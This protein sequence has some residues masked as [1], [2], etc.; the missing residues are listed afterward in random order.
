MT[1]QSFQS[2]YLVTHAKI[3]TQRSRD[4]ALWDS[5]T[6]E[7]NPATYTK[8]GYQ[9]KKLPL[10]QY[11]KYKFLQQFWAFHRIVVEAL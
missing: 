2:A 11:F 10:I 4:E 1:L 5:P 7:Q 6:L 3:L 8:I 9:L